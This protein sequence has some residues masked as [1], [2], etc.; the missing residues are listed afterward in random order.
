MVGSSAI[1]RRGFKERARNRCTLAFAAAQF[2]R[3]LFGI[4]GR[5]VQPDLL[6]GRL[7]PGQ[8]LAAAARALDAQRFRQVL[9]ERQARI[10]RVVGVLEDHANALAEPAKVLARESLDLLPLEEKLARLLGMHPGNDFG[11]DRLPRPA[12]SC[13]PQNFA[14]A[15]GEADTI[16]RSYSLL[17]LLGEPVREGATH[18]KALFK[19]V[20]AQQ[21]HACPDRDRILGIPFRHLVYI[22]SLCILMRLSTKNVAVGWLPIFLRTLSESPL[23]LALS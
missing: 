3:K 15:D 13:E 18:G 4:K 20:R 11:N 10:E 6:E 22:A 7:H 2:M 14:S 23:T 5:R 8:N 1:S 9:D 17:R 12:F 16:N 19:V 21:I